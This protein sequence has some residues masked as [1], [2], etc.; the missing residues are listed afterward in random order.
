MIKEIEMQKRSCINISPFLFIT[1]K[2]IPLLYLHI[3]ECQQFYSSC[4][5]YYYKQIDVYMKKADMNGRKNVL[6]WMN[7]DDKYAEHSRGSTKLL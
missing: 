1:T 3:S 4:H 7:N 2:W 5:E 6:K